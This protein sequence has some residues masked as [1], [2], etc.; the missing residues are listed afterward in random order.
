VKK[1]WMMPCV[2]LALLACGSAAWADKAA[3]APPSGAAPVPPRLVLTAVTK[4][5]GSKLTIPMRLITA[6]M[7]KR[8]R[9]SI[10]PTQT[11]IAGLALSASLT[12][13]GLGWSGRSRRGPMALAAAALAFAGVVGVASA[14]EAPAP[15][16]KPLK[17]VVDQ[18]NGVPIVIEIAGDGNVVNLALDKAAIAAAAANPP[19]NPPPANPAPA[20]QK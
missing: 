11:V 12:M 16:P 10:S 14:D 9:A 7:D 8:P 6:A 1:Q 17:L 15:A 4:E 13:L 20:P 3:P 19:A 2:A 18:P 5:Q